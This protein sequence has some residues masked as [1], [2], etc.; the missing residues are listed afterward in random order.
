MKGG[1]YMDLG[2][3]NKN[4]LLFGGHSNI[5]R[6]VTLAFA[7]EGAGVTIAGRDLESCEKVALEA[8]SLNAMQQVTKIQLM[9]QNLLY[10][11]VLSTVFITV[12][13]G[14]L[15]E[16]SSNSIETYGKKFTKLIFYHV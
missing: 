6:C 14:I 3:K 8:K 12:L 1:T 15:L 13:A 5:G 9:L 16:N 2:L 10:C 7:Q 4:I 11:M